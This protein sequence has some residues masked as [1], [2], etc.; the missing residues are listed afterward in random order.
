MH[1]ISFLRKKN[2]SAYH[3]DDSTVFSSLLL[4]ERIILDKFDIVG[5]AAYFHFYATIDRLNFV[6]KPTA[7]ITKTCFLKDKCIGS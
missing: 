3:S 4:K 5:G 2:E 7:A 1:G 6:T